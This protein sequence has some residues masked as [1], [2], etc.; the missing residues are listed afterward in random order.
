MTIPRHH[1][2][3]TE[4]A[5]YLLLGIPTIGLMAFGIYLANQWLDVLSDHW[6]IQSTFFSAGIIASIFCF[7]RRLRFV[8][9]TAVFIALFFIIQHLSA[10]LLNGEFLSFFF[11]VSFTNYF[12]LFTLGWIAGY[13][14]SRSRFITMAWSILLLAVLLLVIAHI[15]KPSSVSFI[16]SA[17]PVLVFVVYI[18]YIAEL[19]RNMNENQTRFGLFISRKLIAFGLMLGLILFSALSLLKPELNTIE[20]QWEQGGKPK[21]ENDKQS[22]LTR[23]DG[24]GRNTQSS[25]GLQGF[26]NRANKDSVLFVAKLDNYFQDSDVPNPLYFVSDYYTKFDTLTQTFETDT[27]RPYDDLFKPDLLS[28]PL[29]HTLQDSS[30][31]KNSLA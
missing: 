16:W 11:N 27:L 1:S 17:T 24:M 29:Y 20:K 5:Q 26:N 15:S 10:G 22:S 18:I 12:V 13:G 8:T 6:I 4:L 21:E 2:S 14:F 9:L 28:I 25:M 30:V 31:L 3:K 19:L 23:N 7:A